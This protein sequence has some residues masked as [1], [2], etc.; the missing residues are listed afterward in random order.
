MENNEISKEENINLQEHSDKQK[1]TN[2]NV[3]KHGQII[4]GCLVFVTV[5]FFISSTVF[6]NTQQ[7]PLTGN[8]IA[9]DGTS[10]VILKVS[11][12][13]PGHAQLIIRNLNSISGV[14]NV[15]FDFPNI[16]NVEYDL[17]QTTEEDIL[18]LDVFNTYRAQVVG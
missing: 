1:Y 12:P 17:S 3:M 2:N 16:F 4:I 6:S 9:N 15:K 10:T 13:C 7:I 14:K 8:T 18:N 5:L 11:I